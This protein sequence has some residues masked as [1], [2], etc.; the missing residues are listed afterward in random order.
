MGHCI[1]RRSLFVGWAGWAEAKC[2][3]NKSRR[4]KGANIEK[5]REVHVSANSRAERGKRRAPRAKGW[6]FRKCC[7]LVFTSFTRPS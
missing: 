4:R 5:S 6:H 3:A 2:T 1:Y 7:F